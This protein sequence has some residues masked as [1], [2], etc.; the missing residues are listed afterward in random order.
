MR[1]WD[2]LAPAAPLPS[3]HLSA[4]LGFTSDSTPGGPVDDINRPNRRGA[5]GCF[6]LAVLV[7]AAVITFLVWAWNQPG[8]DTPSYW[9]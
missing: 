3:A 1:R 9:H 4:T 5:L 6:V 8:S 2:G 7:V